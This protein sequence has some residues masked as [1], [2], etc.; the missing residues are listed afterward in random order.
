MLNKLLLAAIAAALWAN[1][2]ATLIHPAKADADRNLSEI[3]GYVHDIA[4]GVCSNPK[5]C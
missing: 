1:A 4:Y 2:A 5:I 3:V